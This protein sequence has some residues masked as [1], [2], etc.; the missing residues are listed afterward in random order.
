MMRRE[1]IIFAP[2][3][4]QTKSKR[5]G[6]KDLD[7]DSGVGQALEFPSK[8]LNSRSARWPRLIFIPIL[9]LFLLGASF[10]YFYSPVVTAEVTYHWQK[11]F[12]TP[13]TSPGQFG[14]ILDQQVVTP[15]APPDPN[16]SLVIPK[17]SARS[18]IL[19]NIDPQ[20][21]T[22]YLAALAEGVA[23]AKGSGFPGEGGNIYL[24]AHSTDT[25]FK[26]IRY[27]AVFY[28]LSELVSGDRVEVYF[29]GVKHRY[30]VTEKKI[31]EPTDT[32]YLVSTNSENKEMLILQTCWPPGTT[33]KRLLIFAEKT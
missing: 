13:A 8:S 6:F 2:P 15:L 31:V 21:Q 16:F 18:K 32:S 5:Q 28:L 30:T 25:P 33:L 17:I 3:R 23:H 24:F 20:N 27:N 14:Q 19:A 1:G 29:G 10:I 4:L 11:F 26:A 7:G 22:E 9:I 12:P